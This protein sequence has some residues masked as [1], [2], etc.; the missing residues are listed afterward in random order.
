MK[1]GYFW[2]AGSLQAGCL[3]SLDNPYQMAAHENTL[4]NNEK[5]TLTSSASKSSKKNNF[6]GSVGRNDSFS[7]TPW[8]LPFPI[9]PT[10]LVNLAT[11]HQAWPNLTYHC[12]MALYQPAK[13]HRGIS[14]KPWIND[15]VAVPRGTR[16]S[17]FL[18]GSQN[19]D[20][21]K[22]MSF[23]SSPALMAFVCVPCL[24]WCLH[25][26]WLVVTHII[27]LLYKYRKVKWW[28]HDDVSW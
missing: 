23:K 22:S 21:P 27:L 16:I 19:L 8:N 7:Q 1:P 14:P 17:I 18:L 12:H 28:F 15:P 5:R 10:C 25:R 24:E 3:A 11:R 26:I 2:F 4:E 6:S 13:K 9:Q 20:K